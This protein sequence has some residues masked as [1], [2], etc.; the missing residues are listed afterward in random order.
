VNFSVPLLTAQGRANWTIPIG[1]SYNSQNW[2]QDNGVN[3]QLSDDVGYGFGW[4]LQIGSITPYYASATSGVDHYVYT[5]STGAEYRLDQ[6]NNGVWSSTQGIFVWFDSNA[7]ILHFKNGQFWKMGST[8]GASEPDAGTMYPT[9]IEDTAGNQVL[10]KYQP[11]IG[12]GA[13][14]INTSARINSIEDVR[15]QGA[16]DYTFTYNTD[17]PVPHLS[18]VSNGIETPENFNFS[19]TSNVPVSPPFGTDPGFAGIVTAQLATLTIVSPP[20]SMDVVSGNPYTFLYDSAGAS[21]LNQVTFPFG[22]HLRW[23]YATDGFSGSRL[24]RAA[25]TH[26]LAAD[27][28]GAVEWAYPITRDNASSA[29]IHAWTSLADASGIGS[30]TWDF[31]TSSTAPPGELGLL[32]E[33]VQQ[34]SLNSGIILQDDTYTWS[35]EPATGNPYISSKTT[36]KDKGSSN[37]QSALT[38]QTIDQYGNVT[39]SIAYPYNNTGTP[40]VTYA[41]TYLSGS[42]YASN[43]IFDRL[44]TTTVTTL[45]VTKTLVQ[46]TY[47]TNGSTTVNGQN[48]NYGGND[49]VYITSHET[50]PAP[51]PWGTRGSLVSTTTPVHSVWLVVSHGRVIQSGQTDGENVTISEGADTN[52]AVPETVATPNFSQTLSYNPW[53]GVTQTTDASGVTLQMTYDSIGRP[54]TGRNPWASYYGSSVAPTYTYSYSGSA[55]PVVQTKTGP[56]GVTKTM[57][58]GLGRTVRVAR[59]DST[60]DK[61]WTDTVYAPCACSPLGKIQKVSQPYAAQGTPSAWTVYAY[62]GLGRTLTVQQ[63]DGASSTSYLYSGNQTKVSDPAGNWKQLTNDVLGNL[64]TVVEPDPA[65]P[66]TGTLTTS[67][68]YDWMK[69]VSCVDVTRG[70]TL[71]QAPVSY[72]SNGVSCISYYANGT[73]T[74]Q[75]RTFVFNDAGLLTSA[76]NPE[77]GTVSYSY[78]ADNTLHL[79]QD[80]KGQ[81]SVY[82]YDTHKRLTEVQVFP[83]GQNNPEDVCQ[84]ARYT[85]D[86]SGGFNLGRLTSVGYSNVNGSG[87]PCIPGSTNNYGETFYYWFDKVATKSMS[88]QNHT[89]SVSYLYDYAERISSVIYPITTPFTS[90]GASLGNVYFTYGYDSLGRPATLSGPIP[91]GNTANWVEGAQYDSVG[92]LTQLQYIA[93]ASGGTPSYTTETTGYNSNGQMISQGWSTPSSLGPNGG[94]QYTYPAAGVNNGQITQ[95]SDAISGETVTYAYD[96]LKRL[97]SA[98]STPQ[99]GS[100]TIPWTE[101]FQF[102]G[103]SNLTAKVLNGTATTIPVNAAT[104]QL[105]A[106]SYDLN[107]NMLTGQAPSSGVGVTY[108]YD[109]SNRITS[110]ALSSGGAEYYAYSTDNK[111]VYRLTAGGTEQWTLYG[112]YGEKVGVFQS[113]SSTGPYPVQSNVSFAGRTILDSNFPVF[114]DRLGTNRANGARFYPYGEEI[115]NTSNDREKFATYTRDSHTGLDYADQRFYASTYGRFLTADPARNSA[116]PSDPGSWNRYAYTRGDPVNRFDPGGT[117]DIMISG[118]GFNDGWFP[119]ASCDASL[120]PDFNPSAYAE[121]LATFACARKLG[122]GGGVVGYEGGGGIVTVTNASRTGVNEAV[123]ERR[124]TD[125]EDNIDPGCA[126]WLFGNQPS[127]D[128]ASITNEAITN[129]SVGH[130][131]LTNSVPNSVTNAVTGAPNA[132]GLAIIINDNGAF[133]NSAVTTDNTK[134][135]GGTQQAQIFLLLHEYAHL[136]GA[137]GFQDD[138]NPN[139]TNA[140]NAAN[141]ATNNTTIEQ[142]CQ[143]TINMFR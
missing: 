59:G 77:N 28:Q 20:G 106:A 89:V 96:A 90:S 43:Y 117:C 67:Y 40:L 27:A 114:Q 26:Y 131:I 49:N 82:T 32:S 25:A 56:D 128:I 120:G 51:L 41:N 60:G 29:T 66:P 54:A 94:L 112:V 136:L 45:G 79:K 105:T 109:A 115:T 30:K 64:T 100:S 48:F 93:G 8:S 88:V 118:W 103:F 68:A 62:D 42:T 52:Y 139:A 108:T 31:I 98:S 127:G 12:L 72:T 135:A 1:L 92:R 21:E 95:I 33:L 23:S 122:G 14:Q 134:L 53:L 97:T 37:Q 113:S 2:L 116:G 125:L 13:T 81:Q 57:L 75:T 17:T 71:L 9:V 107:G 80:A 73:G 119:Y 61:Y 84:Q 10:M 99:T 110:A 123:I 18:A 132:L 76:T 121:C 39:Q 7:G 44:L 124:M 6:N 35:Q 140:T 142:K 86:G 24:L 22:G 70:G 126:S 130:G 104:N 85:Y 47:D 15:G 137:P 83:T 46:N 4:K 87:N 69:H 11:G 101:S 16:A 111:R 36:V 50:D 133:F 55:T 19:Y 91:G 5:D 78:N 141:N 143:T 38:T 129:G 74:K 58:D 3:W 34:P 138:A 65:N 102:D 63:P